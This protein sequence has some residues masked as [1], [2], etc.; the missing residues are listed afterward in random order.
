MK[1]ALALANEWLANNKGETE[2]HTKKHRENSEQYRCHRLKTKTTTQRFVNV[3]IWIYRTDRLLADEIRKRNDERWMTWF[4]VSFTL[5]LLMQKKHAHSKLVKFTAQ[6]MF[7]SCRKWSWSYFG[8]VAFVR[9]ETRFTK[10]RVECC[11]LAME[12]NA[13]REISKTLRKEHLLSLKWTFA[14][15]CRFWS[16]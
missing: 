7:R 14:M 6:K 2:T 15:L 16:G 5:H 11:S 1:F 9:K 12:W 10:L 13:M 3:N 8:L 4:W